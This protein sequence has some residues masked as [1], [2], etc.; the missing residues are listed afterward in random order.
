MKLNR[1]ICF[2]LILFSITSNNAYLCAAENKKKVYR[3]IYTSSAKIKNKTDDMSNNISLNAKTNEVMKISFYDF[4]ILAIQFY[5]VAKDFNKNYYKE[6]KTNFYDLYVSFKD[7]KYIC[8]KTDVSNKMAD[9]F[10]SIKNDFDYLTN[11]LLKC[12]IIKKE[13]LKELYLCTIYQ[14]KHGRIK[15]VKDELP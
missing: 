11:Y 10:A 15:E 4:Q 9:S 7:L 1:I 13:D 8:E 12:R 6:I 5:N 3:K 2:F 14:G